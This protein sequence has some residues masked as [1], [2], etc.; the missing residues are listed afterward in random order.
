[1]HSEGCYALCA[2]DLCPSGEAGLGSAAFMSRTGP[3]QPRDAGAFFHSAR[4]TLTRMLRSEARKPP[5]QVRSRTHSSDRVV[6]QLV[7]ST[8]ASNVSIRSIVPSGHSASTDH[9]SPSARTI[10]KM[11]FAATVVERPGGRIRG[12]GFWSGDATIFGRT[13]V[14]NHTAAKGPDASPNRPVPLARRHCPLDH[15]GRLIG[16]HLRHHSVKPA[17]RRQR[18]CRQSAQR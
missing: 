9:R 3:R 4:R 8:W 6:I 14:G 13:S 17:R 18:L 11:G 2:V 12:A 15:A 1:M 10:Q 5:N 7:A 16:L